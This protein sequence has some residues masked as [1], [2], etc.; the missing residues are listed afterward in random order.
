GG[1]SLEHTTKRDPLRGVVIGRIDPGKR[2]DHAIRA[3]G[4]AR[5]SSAL[6]AKLNIVGTGPDEPNLRSLVRDLD[7]SGI[8][9][10]GGFT[11]RPSEEF[12]RSSFSLLASKSE[13]FGIVLVESMN[14]GCISISYDVPYGPAD[15]IHL[16]VN[17]FLVPTGEVRA[18]A[19]T[20]DYVFLVPV[21]YVVIMVFAA[22]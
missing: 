14:A 10:F 16:G 1:G 22:F 15:I 4:A 11:K 8:V 3:L 6:N 21:D 20:V 12:D 13:G 18:L 2:I 19:R 17:V 9:S 7:L 5:K